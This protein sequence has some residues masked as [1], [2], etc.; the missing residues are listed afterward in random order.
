MKVMVTGATGFIGSALAERLA[1]SESWDVRCASRRPSSNLPGEHV[2]ASLGSDRAAEQAWELALESV[3]VVVHCAGRVHVMEEMAADP[4]AAYRQVNVE[5]TMVLARKA[6]EAG[7]KRFIFLSSI[8]VNG[9]ATDARGPFTAADTP[10]PT[11]P[12]SISKWEAEAGLRRLALETGMQ[13]VIIRPVLVYGPGVK[14]N[15]NSMMGW[16]NKGIPLPLGAIHNQRSLVSLD[17]LLD[18]IATTLEHPAAANQVFLVSDGQD[19]STTQ[20]LRQMAKALSRPDRLIPVPA[21][22][23]ECTAS[24]L[25]KRA[26]AQRL[27]ASLQIDMSQTCATLN[28]R[29]PVSQE[30][31]LKRAADAFLRTRKP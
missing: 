24:M 8:K 11:D 22:I 14:G 21:A 19:L 20:L 3:D 16:L 6:A 23:L 12:Y 30:Q 15:F 17:N 4:L 28:W 18:L 10:D 26:V 13:I 25:G 27:C 1:A 9:E 31:G 5:G 29:P 2:I 7:V